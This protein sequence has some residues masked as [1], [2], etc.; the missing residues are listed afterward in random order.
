MS[1][2][3]T[4]PEKTKVSRRDRR[5]IHV[6]G[7]HGTKYSTA[8][9][10]VTYKV[11]DREQFVQEGQI[12]LYSNEFDRSVRFLTHYKDSL[13]DLIQPEPKILNLVMLTALQKMGWFVSINH[14]SMP[15]TREIKYHLE[16]QPV[17]FAL[18]DPV[19]C[20]SRASFSKITGII[21][22]DGDFQYEL[23]DTEIYP[24]SDLIVLGRSYGLDPMECFLQDTRAFETYKLR[25]KD[26]IKKILAKEPFIGDCL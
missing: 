1:S 13:K 4:R 9:E 11:D 12:M 16:R 10:K 19:Y 18:G 22:E 26:K 8:F 2:R 15:D 23:F 14:T 21:L 3:S 5:E 17:A 24:R 25:I 6:V 20:K 7:V